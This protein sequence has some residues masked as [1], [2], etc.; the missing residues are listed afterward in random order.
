MPDTKASRRRLRSSYISSIISIALVLFM[1][2][3]LGLFILDA[4]KISD[5]VKEHIQLTVFL[6]DNASGPEVSALQ[7]L[8]EH[9]PFVKSAQFIS[10]QQALDSLKKDLGADAVSML[11]SNPL[12]ASI[13]L[14]LHAGYAQPDSMQNIA[15]EIQKNKIVRE[16]SYQRTEVHKMNE[17]FR[18]VALVILIFSALLLFIAVAL[19]N[20][21]V[22]L[23]MYSRRFLV[24][25]MQLV[26]ATKGFIR[27]PFIRLSALHG[28]YAGII[29]CVLL[30]GLLYAIQNSFPE[31]MSMQNL[32][33]TGILFGGIIIFGI[34]LASA[35]SLFAVNRYL[36]VKVDDLY[37]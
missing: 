29:A 22:R 24:K 8:L 1:V 37:K 26:G 15:N 16:V 32:N 19:I 13:D 3:L 7:N 35:S 18:T 28:L 30:A 9:S 33:E 2:G 21:T 12:P 17:N 5:Y 4:R 25:S 34:L 10:K 14:K 11:E 20:N 36:N 6:N 23:S 27:K 31:L